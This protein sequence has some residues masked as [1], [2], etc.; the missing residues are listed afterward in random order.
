MRCVTI[1]AVAAEYAILQGL[2]VRIDYQSLKSSRAEKLIYAFI[3]SP[4]PEYR[5]GI[6]WSDKG[7]YEVFFAPYAVTAADQSRLILSRWPHVRP[8]TEVNQMHNTTPVNVKLPEQAHSTLVM[9]G[10]VFQHRVWRALLDIPE[11]ET[12]HY[13]DIAH[14]IGHPRAWRAVANAIAANPLLCLVPCHRVVPRKGGAGD[15]RCGTE[16]KRL[17]LAYEG[18]YFP[19]EE[20]L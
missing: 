11:G 18:I 14:A 7:L 4:C 3:A 8:S 16:L 17:L 1:V 9:S 19:E 20:I 12:R 10:T 5:C 6:V 13:A 15:Y 2:R